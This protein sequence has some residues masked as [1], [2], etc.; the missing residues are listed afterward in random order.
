MSRLVRRVHGGR[1]K[2]PRFG[3]GENS[4][5]LPMGVMLPDG[6]AY[7]LEGQPP[8]ATSKGWG[9]LAWLGGN[10]P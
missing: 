8:L 3:G 5:G 4:D 7:Q 10:T 2:P 6:T 1:P 9:N